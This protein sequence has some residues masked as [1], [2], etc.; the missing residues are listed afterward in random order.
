MRWGWESGKWGSGDKVPI[1]TEWLPSKRMPGDADAGR[2]EVVLEQLQQGGLGE[3]EVW[4]TVQGGQGDP[5]QGWAAAPQ[6]AEESESERP[7]WQMRHLH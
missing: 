4:V 6:K 2:A 1:R 7:A 5:V 3:T